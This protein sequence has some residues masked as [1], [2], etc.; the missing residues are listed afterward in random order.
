MASYDAAQ[1]LDQA[2]RVAGD[3]P[4]PQQVNLA[5]GK[6]GQIDSPRGVWQFNQPRTPQQKWYLR[7]VQLDGQV[8]SNV[9]VTELA[10]LG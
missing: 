7:E 3:T 1:V 5:L 10:T 6:I 2:I 4:N 9:L 8:L